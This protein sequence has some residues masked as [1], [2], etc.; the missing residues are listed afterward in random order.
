MVNHQDLLKIMR[1]LPTDYTDYGGSVVRWETADES[2]PD[3]SCGCKWALWLDKP[4]QSDWCVCTKPGAPRSGL[5]T[6]EH[7]TGR[8]CFD[9]FARS[10]ST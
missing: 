5:L 4:F 1:I 10:E 6:F 3:C 8:G 7:M 2:Y 9:R